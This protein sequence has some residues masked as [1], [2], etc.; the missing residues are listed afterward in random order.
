MDKIT[1]TVVA[2][3]DDVVRTHAGHDRD[4]VPAAVVAEATRALLFHRVTTIVPRVMVVDFHAFREA[5]GLPADP[6]ATLATDAYLEAFGPDELE[7]WFTTYPVL[8]T[9]LDR[10]AHNT[11]RFVGEVADRFVADREALVAH[12]LLDADAGD[13]RRLVPFDSDPHKGGTMVMGLDLASGERLV[14]KPRSMAGEEALRECVRLVAEGLPHDLDGVVPLS[15]DRGAYGW[16]QHVAA[17][18]A[19]DTAD[20]AAYYWRF[21]ALAALLGAVG[22]TD[23][24]EEN[25]VAAGDRPVLIDLETM[26]HAE[27]A[28]GARDI[29][30]ALGDRVRLSVAGTL[31]FPQRMPSGPYSVVLGGVGIPYDQESSRTEFVVVDAGTDAVDIA[32]RTYRFLR[33]QHV[34]ARADGVVTSVLDHY[35]ALEAG[36]VAGYRQVLARRDEVLAALDARPLTLRQIIRPTGSYARLLSAATHPDLLADPAEFERFLA[37]VRPPLGLRLPQV[38]PF[39]E[40]VERESLREGDIPYFSVDS[41]DYRLRSDDELSVPFTDHTPIDRAR[42]GLALMDEDQLLFERLVI[43]DGMSEMRRLRGESPDRDTAPAPLAD[44]VGDTLDWRGVRDVLRRVAVRSAGV[45]GEQQGWI[46]G[47]HA[48]VLPTYDVGSA[49]SL[50]DAGGIGVFLH[51]AAAVAPDAL[52][53]AEV[54]RVDRGQEA[55]VRRYRESLQ[56]LP[57]SVVSGLA[58]L[59]YAGAGRSHDLSALVALVSDLGTR[60][61]PVDL[62]R[63]AVDDLT[64]GLPGTGLL[65]ASDGATPPD[66]LGRV[67]DLTEQ[68]GIDGRASYDLAHGTLGVQWARHRMGRRLG[69]DAVATAAARRVVEIA[70]EPTPPSYRGW[71]SGA[72]ALALVLAETAPTH[73]DEGLVRRLAERAVAPAGGGHDGPVDL[74]VCHG[75]AGVVQVLLQVTQHL[76]APWALELAQE[77]WTR[78]LARARTVGF[79]TGDRAKTAVLGYFHGWAGIADTA[80]LLE[81]ATAGRRGWVPASLALPTFSTGSLR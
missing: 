52:V 74:S 76:D 12:G 58:S 60:D 18:A 47:L 6:D 65:L 31:L 53:A 1:E 43:E 55:L 15:L 2:S 8:R 37:R 4:G 23:L 51:R 33:R 59:T 7:R 36:F 66:V 56:Q 62:E 67:L 49:V 17:R 81:E 29:S 11:A 28:L 50:H 14:H 44:L 79:F 54:A 27:N 24:H 63:L 10:V 20:A 75:A 78:S 35:D 19:R 57:F 34:L 21:G 72:A 46:T 41:R 48:D 32:R 22:A 40:Q 45:D 16:Q 38:V 25:V 73:Q 5:R 30:D 9:M 64:R 61:E 71:C 69:L 70:A 39:I 42:L 80:L 26:L 68:T 3:Y 13:V 77:E